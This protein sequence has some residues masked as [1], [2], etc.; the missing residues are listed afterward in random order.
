MTETEWNLRR[1]LLQTKLQLYSAQ[2]AVL[3]QLADKA[4][5]ELDAMGEKWI[6]APSL[7]VVG[8]AS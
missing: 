3:G 7:Q 4:K 1:E 5:K 8:E 6:E 2:N